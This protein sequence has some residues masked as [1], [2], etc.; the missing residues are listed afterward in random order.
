MIDRMSGTHTGPSTCNTSS[1]LLDPVFAPR[2]HLL[3][4]SRKRPGEFFH[5]PRFLS[6]SR[7]AERVANALRVAAKRPL[8]Q[9]FRRHPT[10]ERPWYAICGSFS[11]PSPLDDEGELQCTAFSVPS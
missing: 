5:A 6:F 3:P 7:D 1:S 8:F 4:V 10:S 11:S 9:D 2:C